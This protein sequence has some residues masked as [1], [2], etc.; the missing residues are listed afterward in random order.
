VLDWVLGYFSAMILQASNVKRRTRILIAAG[1][2]LIVVAFVVLLRSDRGPL[3]KGKRARDW[4]DKLAT[5]HG[6]S[7]E[8]KQAFQEMGA[9]AVPYLINQLT[10]KSAFRDQY[11]VLKSKLPHVL[12]VATPQWQVRNWPERKYAAQALG[13]IGP[14]AVAAIPT[15]IEAVDKSEPSA[16]DRST[17]ASGVGAGF[18]PQARMA[19]IQAL[20]RIDSESPAVVSAV[21]GALQQ[22]YMGLTS[23]TNVPDVAIMV[24]AELGPKS[25]AQIPTVIQNLKF[26]DKK[27][28]R[29]GVANVYP[30][31][32]LAPGYA[33][34]VPKL[35][36]VL[37][38]PNP[39]ARE[40][41]AYDLGTLRP[42][43]MPAAKAAIPA[44]IE[45]LQDKDE[46]VRITVAEAIL[47]IDRTQSQTTIPALIDLLSE[48]NYTVRLRAVDLLRQMGTDATPALPAL[49][50]ALHD[51]ARIVQVWAAEALAQIRS[52]IYNQSHSK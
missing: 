46:I 37:K 40:A 2:V 5:T 51:N 50:Q 48:T 23:Q 36:P 4:L 10:N 3:H 19:A 16:T 44:L 31:G 6:E 11:V 27:W 7:P 52:A 49:E 9:Q 14:T 34:S 29:P 41:A 47:K 17:G 22:K 1:L 25:K 30:V 15:L 38:D 20:W 28:F 26:C 43:E 45:A 33:E 39:R 32:A 8:A 18:Y 13:E 12:F 21:V 42:K 24:L 35:I